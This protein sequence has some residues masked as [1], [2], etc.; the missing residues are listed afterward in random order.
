MEISKVRLSEKLSGFDDYW[1]PRIIAELN[2][3]EVKLVK[4]LGEFV[5]HDHQNE[6][7]LFVVL[8]GCLSMQYVD[9]TGAIRHEEI[10]EGE[11]I[12]MPRGISHCPLARQEV[13]VLLFE[14]KST[15][16]TGSATDVR[17]KTTLEKV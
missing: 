10:R 12:V 6:D 7:E 9:R 11:M 4:F 13:H 17:T 8:K 16:N 15:V 14:P 3:Q 5:W 2:D 1:A